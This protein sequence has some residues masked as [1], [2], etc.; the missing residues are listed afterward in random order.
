MPFPVSPPQV[1]CRGLR[2][3]TATVDAK[4]YFGSLFSKPKVRN[5]AAASSRFCD[6]LKQSSRLHCTSYMHSRVH[7]PELVL[8]PFRLHG[9][10]RGAAPKK[11]M[12]RGFKCFCI[13]VSRD[14]L[15]RRDCGDGFRVQLRCCGGELFQAHASSAIAPPKAGPQETEESHT[16]LIRNLTEAGNF[17]DVYEGL[18]KPVRS[19][20][21]A[22]MFSTQEVLL[23]RHARRHRPHSSS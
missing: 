21:R 5:Y 11:E 18:R 8:H 13:G 23:W 16:T 2:E 14:G 3:I 20:H 17:K 1:R 10:P 12:S 22:L 6:A 15:Y 19:G 9:W 4:Y 7:V